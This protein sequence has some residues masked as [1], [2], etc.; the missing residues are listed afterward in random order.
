[1]QKPND[2]AKILDQDRQEAD[3]RHDSKCVDLG[4]DELF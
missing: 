4:K 2:P 3:T 1:M